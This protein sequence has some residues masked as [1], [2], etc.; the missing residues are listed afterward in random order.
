MPGVS[1]QLVENIPVIDADTHLVEPPDLWTSRMS[2]KWGDLVPHVEWDEEN[3]DEAW[4]IG[5]QRVSSVGGAAMAGWREYP[6]DHPKR[7]G[8]TDPATWDAAVRLKK[9]DEYGIHAQVLYPNVALFNSSLLVDVDEAMTL[10][11]LRAYNDYQTDWSSAAPDRLLPMTSLPFW[12]LDATLAE[13]D[14]CTAMGHRGIVFTQDPSAFGL[15]TLTD[16]ALGP[17]VGVG[18]GE[19]A[20]GE[21]PHRLRRHLALHV[22]RRARSAP[23]PHANY[24]S[25]GVSFFMGNARTISS[26]ICGGICH[27]FPELNF[28]SVESGIGWIPFALE[29][30]D[31]QWKNCGVALE[32]PEYD[33]LPSE[34]FKRQIYGC[35]WF[36]RET[37]RAAID[38]LGDDNF[39][40]ETDF[41]HPTSMSPGPATSAISPRDFIQDSLGRPARLDAAQDPPR[42]RRPHLPPGLIRSGSASICLSAEPSMDGSAPLD[43]VVHLIAD[44]HAVVVDQGAN[45]VVHQRARPVGV[46]GGDRSGDLRMVMVDLVL[47]VAR[48]GVHHDVV[49][50]N[51]TRR[52]RAST[53]ARGCRRGWPRPRGTRRVSRRSRACCCRDHSPGGRS[54]NGAIAFLHRV[55]IL[56]ACR[57]LG[58]DRLGQDPRLEQLGVGAAGEVVEERRHPTEV[59]GIDVTDAR[60]AARA[61]PDGDQ[62][63]DFEESEGLADRLPAHAILLE[64]GGLRRQ[65]VAGRAD[66]G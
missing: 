51:L 45:V 58:K 34:Y 13:I 46:P 12:D 14:R 49:G 59:G 43:E 10:E 35:F 63:L 23:D 9:M 24:A 19:G 11:F 64:H 39:L 53:R 30:L 50:D 26:L 31:W 21:L 3:G 65:A 61:A 1:T 15:P 57:P 18:A 36:E 40:Y 47:Q 2:S 66:L 62:A 22:G 42:Q 37:A 29:S 56:V 8:D 38:W 60:T 33:L 55:A 17:D 28:V 25:M 48:V 5:G 41:P 4:F 20:A 32:H 54:V 44:L 16:R 27:R 7:W 6:P 52:L